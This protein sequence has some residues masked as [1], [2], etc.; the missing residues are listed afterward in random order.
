[1]R[2]PLYHIHR[3]DAIPPR[4]SMLTNLVGVQSDCNYFMI[5]IPKEGS[6]EAFYSTLEEM[7]QE[8]S[9]KLFNSHIQPK[10]IDIQASN[11]TR[12]DGN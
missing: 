9:T 3:V 2:Y 7:E 1:M 5:N 11:T 8:H 6:T 4:G 12:S 10:I